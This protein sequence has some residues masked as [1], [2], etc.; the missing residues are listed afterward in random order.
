MFAIEDLN[1]L[2]VH[3]ITMLEV[4]EDATRVKLK[5]RQTGKQ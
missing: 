2:E 5:E 1:L 3:A 4:T